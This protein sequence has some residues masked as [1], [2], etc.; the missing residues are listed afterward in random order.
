MKKRLLMILVI[1][2]VVAAGIIAGR[3]RA[4]RN[5]RRTSW[6]AATIVLQQTEYGLK[7]EV[8]IT[9]TLVRYQHSDGTWEQHGNRGD[10]KPQH[11][12]GRVDPAR[13][14]TIAE[15]ERAAAEFGRREDQLLGYRVFI[16]KNEREEFWYAPDLDAVLKAV[17]YNKDGSISDVTEAISV[18]PGEPDLRTFGNIEQKL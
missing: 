13:V 16:Q 14:P 11:S 4:N 2:L 10:S 8:L 18:T 15:Y 6:P 3:A 5:I 1:G 7:G 12:R 9:V 17:S